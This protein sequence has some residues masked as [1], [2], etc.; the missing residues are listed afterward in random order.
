ME[1]L[2]IIDT[3][4]IDKLLPIGH[5]IRKYLRGR[6]LGI[7]HIPDG[8]ALL[9]GN[10][11]A[12]ITFLEP[13]L[14]GLAWHALKQGEDGFFYLAHDAL[15][16]IPGLGPILAKGGAVRAN[17]RNADA[18]FAAGRKVAVWPG[19]NYEAFRPWSQRHQVDFGGHRGFVRL[20]LR[21]QVPIVPVMS[22]G[23]HEA[24][25]VLS[26]GERFAEWTGI[27]KHFRSESFP[28]FLGLPWGVGVGPL[29]HLPLPV[30]TMVEVGPPIPVDAYPPDA[31]SDDA[32]V[33]S[34]YEIVQE[35]I[36]AMMDRQ[37]AL[38]RWGWTSRS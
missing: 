34:L 17:H 8:P 6:V 27:K 14:L 10:H 37:L 29:V 26:R 4:L 15:M 28:L 13:V 32:V 22:L 31:A 30:R 24:Y 19:G 36:Q 25:F 9:V 21:N 12:G 2:P 35:T 33:Q 18:V 3:A 38:R 20:A 16:S 23:G 5:V 1:E 7:E 11:N